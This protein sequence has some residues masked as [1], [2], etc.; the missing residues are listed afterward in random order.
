MRDKL[1]ILLCITALAACGPRIVQISNDKCWDVK[2]GD[3]VSGAVTVVGIVDDTSVE[4]GAYIQ[5]TACP[6]RTIGLAIPN[7]PLLD[8]YRKAM[9]A[10]PSGFVERRFMLNGEIYQNA[11]SRRL[12]VRVTD[13]RLY[14]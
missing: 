14:I 6:D 12:L 13:L 9:E 5:N 2:P 1:A 11:G 10:N 8:S 7:G 3:R 4:G